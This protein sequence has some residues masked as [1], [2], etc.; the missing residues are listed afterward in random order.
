MRDDSSVHVLYLAVPGDLGRPNLKF[1]RI[2]FCQKM[3]GQ[4]YSLHDREASCMHQQV[5]A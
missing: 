3:A 2:M 5:K 1:V 4:N